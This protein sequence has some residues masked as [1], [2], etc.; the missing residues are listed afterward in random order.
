[1][2]DAPAVIDFREEF[3]FSVPP[4][5]VWDFIERTGEFERLWAWLGDFHLD[6]DGLRAGSVLVGEVS[7]P[8]PYRM[9]VRVVLG[10]CV[11]PTSID[12]AVHGDLEGTARLRIVG[13]Q[14]GS[15]VAVAWRIEMMQR[16]MRIADRVAHP[17]LR[18]G[19]DRVVDATVL[20]FRHHIEAGIAPGGSDVSEGG[21]GPAP[22]PGSPHPTTG[23]AAPVRAGRAGAR[24]RPG[25]STRRSG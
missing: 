7:P 15:R 19:H 3:R 5:T 8:V 4:P 25:S 1:M 16:A 18:W 13:E 21:P 14:G 6:G 9:R 20:S 22:Q 11:R 12:A 10:D 2:P 17:L 23:P 24:R